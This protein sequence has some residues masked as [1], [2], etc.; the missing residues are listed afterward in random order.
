MDSTAR[1]D[2]AARENLEAREKLTQLVL[3]QMGTQVIAAAARLGLADL[4]GDAERAATDLAADRRADPE[5]T[6]RLLRAM[7]ALEL[8]VEPRPGW[9]ALTPLGAL[10]RTDRRDSMHA[11][12]RMFTDRTMLAGW[13]RLDDS[14]LSG[15]PTFDDLHG[16]DFFTHLASQPE[17]SALFN[18]F[19]SQN[20]LTAATVT[21]AC[22]DFGRHRTIV[23][24][25]GGDGTLLATILRGHAKPRG[26]LFDT[27]AGLAEAPAA[28]ERAGVAD[29]CALVS[30]DFFIS[31]PRDGD[32][33]LLK[34]VLHDWADDKAAEVLAQV[35]RAMGER[36]R[37]LILERVLPD[38]VDGSAPLTSYLS[39]LN[40]M[41]NL[42]GRERRA[43]DFI[44]LCE[45]S[46][47]ADI[48]ITPL[49]APA[50]FSLIEAV[51]APLG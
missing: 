32:L 35:R 2:L 18:T 41:V 47:F 36:S 16:T 27:P 24:V 25:G 19:M 40:M 34:S 28:L 17:L 38:I 42:G 33:Y 12:A 6:T 3:A 11:M 45:H 8:L 14:V 13:D 1:E 9:F 48:T 5:S 21:S 51:P 44:A 20:T 23:D 31:V 29:R 39:D 37:L 50:T 46:G 43:A 49:P 7:A 22:Y 4:I 15:K 26:V 10:L 30:G